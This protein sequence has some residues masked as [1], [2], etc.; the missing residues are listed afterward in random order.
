MLNKGKIRPSRSPY[1]EPL[2]FV[3]QKDSL[4]CVIDYRALNRITKRN[5]APIP[6]T[7]GMFDRLGRAAVYSKLGL[8]SGFHQIRVR[9]EDIEKTAFKTKYGHFEFL[10]MPMRLYNALATFQSLM[11]SIFSDIIIN[12]LVVYLDDLLVYSNS[13]EEHL[14]HLEEVL[15]RLHKNQLYV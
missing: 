4:R 13:Y 15:S 5:N 3:K 14:Q 6:K 1:G 7:D 11:N 8:K 2:F 12:Y 9:E 10:V